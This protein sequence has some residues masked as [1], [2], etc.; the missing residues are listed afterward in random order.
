[1]SIKGR[2]HSIETFGTVDG[3]GIRYI[4]FTQGCP[5]RCKYCHNRDTWDTQGGKEYN[6]NELIDD[7][8][9]YIPFMKTS[10]G[11]LTVSGGEPTLQP[12]F[13]KRLLI[14]AKENGIHTAV[15]TSG[16]VDIEVIDPILDYIDLVL[17]DIKHIDRDSFKNLTGVYND[18]TLSLAKHLEK[19]NIPVWIRYVLVPGFT[20]NK[21]DIKNL[22]KFLLTL[23][24]VEKIEVLPYHSMGEFKWNELGYEYPLKGIYDATDEEVKEASKIFEKIMACNS[25]DY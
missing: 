21:D 22:A 11:G 16:F 1:M 15:D 2:I 6:V 4:V 19:R 7:V 23:G 20:D 3:P 13:L 24:N 5:L 10:G 17:L 25:I 14:E 9:K 12:E 8:K 18:K